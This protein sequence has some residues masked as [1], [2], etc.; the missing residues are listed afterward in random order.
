VSSKATELHPD[1]NLRLG[2]LGPHV[3]RI[4]LITGVLFL[5]VTL[6]MGLLV[7]DGMRRFFFSYL[8]GFSF[9]LTLALGALFFTVIQHLVRAR[10]SV[11]VR[12]L[13]EAM[14]GAFPL[15]FGLSLVIVIPL[16]LGHT[17]LYQWSDP[18]VVAHSYL[19]SKKT[20]YLNVPFFALRLLVYF[21]VWMA[22]AHFFF[23]RSV[24]QDETGDPSH[25]ERMRVVSAP[26]T[27]AFA[28][29]ANFAAFDLLMSLEPEWFSSIYG[30]YVFAGSMIAL[31]STMILVAMALQSKGRLTRSITTEHYHD[32][33]K[34]LFAFVFFWG[35][36]AFSQFM[37]I[38]YSN[39]PEETYWFQ[40]RFEGPWL[41]MSLVL[42]FLHFMFPFVALLSRHTKRRRATLAFFAVWMLALH[43]LDLYWLILPTF[44]ADAIPFHLMDITA[45]LGIGGLFAAVT[46]HLLSRVDL[47]PKGDPNLGKSL[48]FENI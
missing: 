41:L 39:I 13:S 5:V 47:L 28:F 43:W 22:L 7:G 10:W 2:K 24:K 32:L 31:F 45:T 23:H 36:I 25:S 14:T 21:G 20:G 40:V 35:Y 38:W 19:L 9:F 46:T 6:I 1:E 42:L 48:E 44:E 4:S 11:V 17:G 34:F 33:G 15:L 29:T 16:L 37:L 12:R 18:D 3:F 30:V 8:L 26:A 27:I